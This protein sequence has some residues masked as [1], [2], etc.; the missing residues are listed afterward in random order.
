[1]PTRCQKGLIVPLFPQGGKVKG[2]EEG[3][4]GGRE[5]VERGE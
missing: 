1:M 2:Q 5:D 4:E 3:G